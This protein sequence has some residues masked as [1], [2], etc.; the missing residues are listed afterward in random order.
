MINLLPLSD[1]EMQHKERRL[2]F[3]TTFLTLFVAVELVSVV[4]LFG[5]Y[6]L[7]SA[8]GRVATETLAMLEQKIA[9]DGGESYADIVKDTNKRLGYFFDSNE[10]RTADSV[11]IERIVQTIPVGISISDIALD[12]LVPETDPKDKKEP[13]PVLGRL[14][15]VGGTAQNRSALLAFVDMLK[16]TP[17]ITG[18]DLPVS[19]FT[20]NTDIDFSITFAAQ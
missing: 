15:Y 19:S 1:K 17:G 8:K 14:V 5:P 4:L 16:K 9:R 18:V 20:Q 7:A 3:V 13:E 10:R 2:R 12:P 11:L 6:L